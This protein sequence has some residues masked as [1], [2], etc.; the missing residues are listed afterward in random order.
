MYTI[1]TNCEFCNVRA[2]RDESAGENLPLLVEVVIAGRR[3]FS[4]SICADNIRTLELNRIKKSLKKL[5]DK[6]I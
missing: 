5:N 1:E 6:S 4:C 3:Y 2:A